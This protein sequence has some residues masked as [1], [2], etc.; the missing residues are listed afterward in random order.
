[1][2]QYQIP[3][4]EVYKKGCMIVVWFD[5]TYQQYWDYTIKEALQLFKE[6]TGIQGSWKRSKFCPFILN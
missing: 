6:K 2:A 5:N 1:M 3:P 4:I